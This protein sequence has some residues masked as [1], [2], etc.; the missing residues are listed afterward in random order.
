MAL[1]TERRP[2]LQLA[3]DGGEIARTGILAIVPLNVQHSLSLIV[4]ASPASP[5]FARSCAVQPRLSEPEQLPRRHHFI[6]CKQG[7]VMEQL[8]CRHRNDTQHCHHFEEE[9]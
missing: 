5:G 7:A 1:L 8:R 2:Q 4:I 6:F 3:I 9:K